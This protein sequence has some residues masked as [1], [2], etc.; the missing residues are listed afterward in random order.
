MQIAVIPHCGIAGVLD[1][2]LA[3]AKDNFAMGILDVDEQWTRDVI[4]TIGDVLE[5]RL[6]AVDVVTALVTPS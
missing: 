1:Y 6:L 3:Q 4:A 5:G 2:E